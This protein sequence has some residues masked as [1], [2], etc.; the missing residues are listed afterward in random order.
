MT[1]S[2]KP[3]DWPLYRP[4]PGVDE[5]CPICGGALDT[6]D[7]VTWWCTMCPQLWELVGIQFAATERTY[8][9][10]L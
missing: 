10:L 6:F 1:R 2:L 9:S 4:L 8:Q 3:W 7:T 5:H